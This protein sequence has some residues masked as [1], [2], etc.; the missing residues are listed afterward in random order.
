MKF[1][2]L[3]VLSTYYNGKVTM[4]LCKCECGVEKTIRFAHV[5]NGITVSCGC[6]KRKHSVE[7]GQRFGRLVVE[8]LDYS[9]EHHHLKVP[10][11]CD[12]G[13]KKTV[14]VAELANGVTKSC[15]CLV[16]EQ[17]TAL[18]YKHGGEGTVLYSIWRGMKSRCANK[19]TENY[20]TYGGRGI[21]VCDEW[22][23]NFQ[24]FKQWAESHGYEKGLQIDRID[25]NGNYCPENC[26]WVTP[27]INGNNRRDNVV[28]TAFGEQ[29]TMKNWSEDSRC[30][31]S[32][33]TLRSRISV[34]K[35]PAF[36]AITTPTRKCKK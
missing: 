28:L 30:V 29:K 3:E 25:V 2:R 13:T 22:D 24:P 34:K 18:S 5:R 31:V 33:S 36:E 11:I 20:K 21:S 27:K 9:R 17:V 8:S 7:A 10:V 32:Y 1:G 23:G 4:A 16:I 26:R 12:C 6:I 35:W 15:G 19:N 14:G